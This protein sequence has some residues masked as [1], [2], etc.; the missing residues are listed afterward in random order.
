MPPQEQADLWMALR[1]R[2]KIDWHDLTMAEKKAGEL[3]VSYRENTGMA[4]LMSS[5]LAF[6]LRHSLN[7]S[8]KHSLMIWGGK[9]HAD[10]APP[11]AYWIAFGPHG[12][13]SLPPPGE[14][15]MIFKYV[16]IAIGISFVLFAMVRSMARPPPKTM[17]A[18]Y[19]EMTN[20]YLRVRHN[21]LAPLSGRFQ[22]LDIEYF[23]L[24]NILCAVRTKTWNQSQVY[25]QKATKAKAWC[26]VNREK[27]AFQMS[28]LEGAKG[29]YS[30]TVLYHLLYPD[31]SE[32]VCSILQHRMRVSEEVGSMAFSICGLFISGG[33][34]CTNAKG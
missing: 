24:A 11:A 29:V 9:A 2:M 18:E 23:P 4:W 7:G 10:S 26:K 28:R 27:G 6:G 19:Q 17:T 16:S 32:T 3:Q 22:M 25:P 21:P 31:L 15:K 20:E 34:S 1:D 14:G 33:F 5:L 8:K 12:P 13:R 30:G